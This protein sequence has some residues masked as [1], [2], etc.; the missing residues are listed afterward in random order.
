[1]NSF[2]FNTQT[3]RK[4][5]KNIK[6]KHFSQNYHF[7]EEK[8]QFQRMHEMKLINRYSLNYYLASKHSS[9]FLVTRDIVHIFS[10]AWLQK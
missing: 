6:L 2:V 8:T 10:L 1:M 7:A 4:E 9:N 3:K 5:E